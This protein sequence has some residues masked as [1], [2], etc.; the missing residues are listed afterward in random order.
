MVYVASA[1]RKV[2]IF[3]GT[4]HLGSHITNAFLSPP[5]G[6]SFALVRLCA[7]GSSPE[8]DKYKSQGAEIALVDF[9]KPETVTEALKDID[10]V[11][12]AIGSKGAGHESKKVL[13]KCVA[14]IGTVKLDFPSEFGIDH[15]VKDFDHAEWDA[16][17]RA[18]EALRQATAPHGTKICAVYTSLFL[19]DSF[20]PWFGLATKKG[21][22]DVIHNPDAR[23]SFT[24]LQDVGF[25]L[26]SLSALPYNQIPEHVRIGGDTVTVREAA[27]IFESFNPG[28]DINISTIPLE[29]YKSQLTKG[30]EGNN[31]PSG[32][33]R[34]L[35]GEGKL[36][37]SDENVRDGGS[38]NEVVNPGGKLWKWRS[39]NEYAQ[40]VKGKPW[41]D[42]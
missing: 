33:L 26:T 1:S 36:D 28:H 9:S 41:W 3:G 19:E 40:N 27:R 5:S 15:R 29:P 4:G 16:K 39:V 13:A 11:V 14:E 20:G 24:S 38:Q 35:M 12:N 34:F 7:R 37:L 18:Q 31:E 32:F 22:W 10:V 23:V 25:A 21:Q 17:M 2:A 42:V 6:I 30:G 8:V